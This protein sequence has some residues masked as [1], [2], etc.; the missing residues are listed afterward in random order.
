MPGPTPAAG[1]DDDMAAVLEARRREPD[2]ADCRDLWCAVLLTALTDVAELQRFGRSKR[3]ANAGASAT[4]HWVGS[5]DF[6]MVC[7][8]AGVDADAVAQAVR[9]GRLDL[10]VLS[11]NLVAWRAREGHP[12]GGR[13]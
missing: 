4:V 5:R 8:L 3:V 9:G 1:S 2:A 12:D 13:A 7:A 6:R 11:P 10:A